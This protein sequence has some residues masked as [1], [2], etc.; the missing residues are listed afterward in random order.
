MLSVVKPGKP[1]MA[2][3]LRR[4]AI[5]AVTLLSG[6][7]NAPLHLSRVFNARRAHAARKTKRAHQAPVSFAA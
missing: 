4:S 7:R 1:Y 3:V 6:L 2:G 5:R